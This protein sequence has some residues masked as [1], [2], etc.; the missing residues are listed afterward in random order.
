VTREAAREAQ[1][2]LVQE[3]ATPTAAKLTEGLHKD[4]R[5]PPAAVL[6]LDSGVHHRAARPYH[7]EAGDRHDECGHESLGR[8]HTVFASTADA[9]TPSPVRVGAGRYGACARWRDHPTLHRHSAHSSEKDE[10]PGLDSNQEP[11]G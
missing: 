10:L 1:Q 6:D 11:I 3:R 4:E 7:G 9:G 5:D 8:R 2:R